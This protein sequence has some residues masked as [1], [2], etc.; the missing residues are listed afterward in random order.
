MN[1]DFFIERLE[2]IEKSVKI[3][4]TIEGSIS[5]S[6]VPHRQLAT[7]IGIRYQELRNVY[8]AHELKLLVDYYTY[9]EQLMKQFI[10]SVLDFDT[11]DSNVHRKKLLNST[12]KPETFSPRVKYKEIEENLNKYLYVSAGK[13]KLLSFCIESDTK[14]KH[15]EL[16]LARHTYAHKGEKP[17]FSILSYVQSN[18][19]F[20]KFLLNDFQNINTHFSIR[21]DIQEI[22]LQLSEEKKKLESMDDKSRNWKQRFYDLREKA[23]NAFVLLSQLEKKSDTYLLLESQLSKFEKIDLRRTLSSNK[24]IVKEIDFK[25]LANGQ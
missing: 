17:S 5:S 6:S 9:C 4:N 2:D 24:N 23:S 21:L 12:L 18:I 3:I 14:N 15:D 22:T 8:E 11:I 7:A 13:I 10:Y 1:I 25:F 19:V 20:L 16:V